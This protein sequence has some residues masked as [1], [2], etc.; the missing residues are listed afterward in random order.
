[1]TQCEQ[2]RQCVQVA[3]AFLRFSVV[4]LVRYS[5]VALMLV[6]VIPM[7][8][9]GGIAEMFAWGVDRWADASQRFMQRVHRWAAR[10]GGAP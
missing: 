5:L 2:L 9:A 8:I 7:M 1:M 6:T 10:N 3:V 4:E